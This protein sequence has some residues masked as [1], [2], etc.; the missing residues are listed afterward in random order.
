MGTDC[1]VAS[2]QTDP[3]AA[4]GIGV[5]G[6]QDDQVR[7]AYQQLTNRIF[8][9]NG[10]ALIRGRHAGESAYRWDVTS[11][12]SLFSEDF[13]FQIVNSGGGSTVYRHLEYLVRWCDERHQAWQTKAELLERSDYQCEWMF[14]MGD[15]RWMMVV[16]VLC[17]VFRA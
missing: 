16:V 11:I 17:A 9:L 15:S 6:L 1:L 14:M 3:S 8:S 7:A 4:P 5:G 10:N 12:P 2:T 13:L